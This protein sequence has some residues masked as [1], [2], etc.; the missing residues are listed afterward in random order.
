[1]EEIAAQEAIVDINIQPKDPEAV[2]TPPVE[3]APINDVNAVNNSDNSDDAVVTKK[4]EYC[5]WNTYPVFVSH[6]K[7]KALPSNGEQCI[8]IPQLKSMTLCI[9]LMT[10]VIVYPPFKSIL[11]VVN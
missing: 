6:R 3:K 8:P 5:V 10:L 11:C 9:W 7:P 1:M 2:L 4:K